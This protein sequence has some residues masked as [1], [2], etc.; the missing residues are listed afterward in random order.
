MASATVHIEWRGRV[1]PIPLTFQPGPSTLLD[2]LPAARAVAHE[3][4]AVGIANATASGKTVSCRAGCGACCRQLVAISF[5]EARGVA[6]TVARLPA[7]KQAAVRQRFADA[8][9]RL[10]ANGLLDPH[11]EKG[12]RTLLARDRGNRDA[13]L[14]DLSQNYFRLQIAC[15]FLEEESCGIHPERPIVCREH[16]VTTPAESCSRLHELNVDRLEP[17]ARIGEALARTIDATTSLGQGMI[18]LVLSL[19]WSEANPD[20]LAQR[21]D[22]VELLQMFLSQIAEQSP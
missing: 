3:A 16:H 11:A 12:N 5:I 15:P 17:A 13:T 2:L 19:E 4:I 8:I 9:A 6:D 20:A 1:S 21:R 22:G 10:E 14:R 7:E 18:P